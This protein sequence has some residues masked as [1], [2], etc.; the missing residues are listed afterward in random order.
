MPLFSVIIPAF[1]RYELTKRAVDSVLAQTFHDYSLV[2]VDDGS[3]DNTRHMEE[4][5]RGRI[6]YI[7]Q[8]NMGVSSARNRGIGASDSAHIAFLDSD[9]EWL[10]GKLGSHFNYI[11]ENRGAGIHQTA[12][13]WIRKGKRVNHGEK[14]LK[15]GGEIFMDSLE[16]CLI[17]PSAVCIDR[18]I[19]EKFGLFDKDLPA[20]ED[21][22][23]WLRI[24]SVEK[25]GLINDELV[26]KY[27]GHPDQ[28]SGKF[29]GMDRF[30]VYSIIKLLNNQGCGIRMDY[31]E[32]A[33]N[34]AL[35]KCRILL[36]GA[37]KRDKNDFARGIELI[38]RGI[39]DG[40]YSSIDSRILLQ[41]TDP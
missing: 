13:R 12:E 26:I 20:C 30:R 18:E 2:L 27:G 24:T 6:T 33:R 14:H 3:T 36:D 1:N 8:E 7:R 4:E 29:W 5:Y 10:P 25:A 16:L 38:M 11:R 9:D 32:A 19:F 34:V 39:T 17:S 37:V 23:L 21:Y 40:C 28:L 31:L 41:T 35:K 22:D 15:R